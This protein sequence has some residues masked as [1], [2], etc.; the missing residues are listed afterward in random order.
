VIENEGV[1]ASILEALGDSVELMNVE[2][3]EKSPGLLPND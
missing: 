3:T 2:I 1:V